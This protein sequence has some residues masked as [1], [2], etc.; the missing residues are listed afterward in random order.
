MRSR[1]RIAAL[2]GRLIA[3][4]RG[5]VSSRSMRE[6]H[7]RQRPERLLGVGQHH[8]DQPLDQIGLDRGVGPA[9]DAQR[10]LAAAAAEQ[11]VDHRIDQAG[12]HRREAEIF[13]FLGLEHAEHGRQ[14]DRIHV[15]AEPHRGDA[16]ERDFDVVGG[17]IAQGRGHQPHQAVEHD[18]EHRQTLVGD[19]RQIDD[20]ANAGIVV[21]IDVA[22]GET[23]QVVDFLLRQNPLAAVLAAAEVAAA[24]LDHG[25]PLQRHGAGEFVGG[26][27][28]RGLRRDPRNPARPPIGRQW[29]PGRLDR[30]PP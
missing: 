15:V 30:C 29:H 19:H 27:R 2:A 1:T 6:G 23:E 8:L 12:I 5:L 21:E 13:P 10:G 28:F 4:K 18:F 17:E 26:S 9:F 11:H 24:V 3:A 22:D 16:V 20:R 14:R 25:G 7:R